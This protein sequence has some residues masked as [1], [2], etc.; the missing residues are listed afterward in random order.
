MS[1]KLRLPFNASYSITMHTTTEYN[2]TNDRFT[3][4]NS[5]GSS[6]PALYKNTVLKSYN[7][8]IHHD[9]STSVER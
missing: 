7:V 8:N 5:S 2:I 1:N 3:T 9:N 6:L 4:P